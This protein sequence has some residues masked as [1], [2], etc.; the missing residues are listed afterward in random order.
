M[1]L[2]PIENA[3]LIQTQ[4][5]AGLL[6]HYSSLLE[7]KTPFGNILHCAAAYGSKDI[8]SILTDEE[9]Q[10]LN[11]PDSNDS[12]PLMLAV[13][14]QRLEMA[15]KL[16]SLTQGISGIYDRYVPEILNTHSFEE[17]VKA[18]DSAKKNSHTKSSTWTSFLWTSS[19]AKASTT[20]ADPRAI[21][22][23][24][25]EKV[26][27][28]DTQYNL[29]MRVL[30]NL[31]E[32]LTIEPELSSLDSAVRAKSTEI[33]KLKNEIKK[34]TPGP[35]E[36]DEEPQLQNEILKLTPGPSELDDEE[37]QKSTTE[38]SEKLKK[39]ELLKNTYEQSITAC[40][41]HLN[42]LSRRKYDIEL[43]LLDV[44]EQLSTLAKSLPEL[45]RLVTLLNPVVQ[46]LSPLPT[47]E[48]PAAESAPNA[49]PK[50]KSW[51][52]IAATILR[53]VATTKPLSLL[54]PAL[55]VLFE[56]LKEYT[57]LECF[58]ELHNLYVDIEKYLNIQFKQ[59]GKVP[60][61]TVCPSC[62]C[63]IQIFKNAPI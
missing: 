14:Y 12:T 36:D 44:F 61:E 6:E 5:W 63:G 38:R 3:A 7:V 9:L 20:L 8:F 1:P 40:Q 15:R 11:V 10:R 35:L 31:E 43:A 58:K 60:K 21:L 48:L 23:Q 4:N 18:I 47:T 22:E 33:K 39:L 49:K 34:L 24:L 19:K 52:S 54:T 62:H 16:A 17:I 57:N 28:R 30:K 42:L 59:N 26:L 46:A 50:P 37:P 13:G 27:L 55:D 56:A 32:Y 45:T 53:K 2:S 41:E 51:W 25:K 29:L